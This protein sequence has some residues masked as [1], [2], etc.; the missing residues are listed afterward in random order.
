MENFYSSLFLIILILILPLFVVLVNDYCENR[1]DK[2]VPE[3]SISIE[4]WLNE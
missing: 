1:E 4:E 2:C 3:G